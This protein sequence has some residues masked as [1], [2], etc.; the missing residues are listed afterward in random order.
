MGKGKKGNEDPDLKLLLLYWWLFLNSVLSFGLWFFYF[1]VASKNICW[2]KAM[3]TA[4]WEVIG[5]DCLWPESP[6]VGKTK[7][8]YIM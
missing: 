5:G 6:L 4:M 3:E 8:K 2:Q 1:V 7:R